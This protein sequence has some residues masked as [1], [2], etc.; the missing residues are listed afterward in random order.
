MRCI[1]SLTALLLPA[2]TMSSLVYGTENAR[3]AELR[4]ESKINLQGIDE[5]SPRLSWRMESA[6]TGAAQ[7]A[8]QIQIASDKERLAQGRADIWDSGKIHSDAMSAEI[9][10]KVAL[11]SEN[12]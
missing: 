11:L 10:G 9:P 2:I 1:I 7:T 4:C 6:A 8:Y 3:P 12:R 5:R